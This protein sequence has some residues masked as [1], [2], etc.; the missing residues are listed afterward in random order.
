MANASV[1]APGFAGRCNRKEIRGG[2]AAAAPHQ[3]QLRASLV[4]L[5]QSHNFCYHRQQTI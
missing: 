4:L 2:F 3:R 1:A 5:R